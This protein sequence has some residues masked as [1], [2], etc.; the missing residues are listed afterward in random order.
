MTTRR[1]D[2]TVK[3]FYSYSHKDAAYRE[4]METS[5]ELL[6]EHDLIQQWSDVEIPPGR[7]ISP[8]IRRRMEESD[9]GVFLFSRDFLASDECKNEWRYFANLSANVKVLFRV[10]I[11]LRRCPWLEFL[12]DD[13]VKALPTDGKAV[14]AFD[15][16]DDAWHDIYEGI[17]SVV[18]ELRLTFSP[19]MEFLEEIEKTEFISQSHITLSELFVFPRLTHFDYTGG[20]QMIRRTTIP[21]C[22]EL[23]KKKYALIHGE[24]KSG[25]TVLARHMFMYL[26]KQNSP[27]ILLDLDDSGMNPNRPALFSECYSR[28]FHGDYGLWC[29]QSNK[30][31]ILDNLTSMPPLLSLLDRACT[32]FE[33]V[34]VMAS[35]DVFYAFFQ[36]EARLADFVEI[37]LETLS[38]HQQEELIRKRMSVSIPAD[39]LS[40]GLIDRLAR[41]VN[42]IV[43]SDKIFPRYPFYVLSILQSYEGYMPTNMAI[44]SYG[45]CYNVLIVASLVRAGI[46]PSDDSVNACFNFAE[47][48]A[49]A[50][51]R[52]RDAYG[53][54]EFNFAGFEGRYVKRFIIDAS[55]RNRLRHES[56]GI[57]NE[58]GSFRT[59][60]MYHFF[61][62]RYLARHSDESV[63]IVNAMCDA[64][65]IEANYFTLMFA[66]HHSHDLSIIDKLRTNTEDLVKHVSPATLVSSETQRFAKVLSEIPESILSDDSIEAERGREN[67]RQ[68]V[69]M[70]AEVEF[71]KEMER[72][73]SRNSATAIYK[74]FKNT[75]ILGQILRSRHGNLER[76]I[77]EELIMTI[78]D[79]GLRLVRLI[80]DDGW[81]MSLLA[82]FVQEKH[83]VSDMRRIRR[84]LELLSLTWTLVNI[85][86][87]V[88]ALNAPELRE[89]ISAVVA[90][91]GTPAYALVGFFSLLE[92]AETLTH[93]ERDQLRRLLRD[94]D[95]DFVRRVLSLR[96]QHYL[97]TH[98]SARNVEQSVCSLLGI[99]YRPRVIGDA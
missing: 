25:K 44:T 70:D 28:Q 50:M 31:I 99:A 10:P 57:I 15:N 11:I 54:C 21:D 73:R 58:D 37:K 8:E 96:T 23:L 29:Q 2:L 39:E 6:R 3:L 66:I 78:T 97:N 24:D 51:Y 20:D 71:D 84:G 74:V 75:K 67:D 26:M 77:V 65:H 48:L 7:Q 55:V 60:Y 81:Q 64:S 59:D 49:F 91:V 4:S 22:A 80:L 83:S 43:V 12:G 46:R 9:I 89:A 88:S 38:L 63:E 27:A 16:D 82:I 13:D 53:N 42:S 56:F 14:A 18:E 52:A 68:Q 85:Q 92:S 35:S 40:D 36:D 41:R 5:L 86:Q 47:Q 76:S 19:R 1:A 69:A 32:E 45:H 79:S 98:R 34:I 17:K 90:R 93:V 94:H 61:L 95:Q 30:T 72:Q 87:L 33:N 62:G